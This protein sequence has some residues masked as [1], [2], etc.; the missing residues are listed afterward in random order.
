MI[1]ITE[2]DVK[3]KASRADKPGGQNVNHRSTKIE[4]W[5]NIDDLPLNNIEKKLIKGKLK[6]HINKKNEIWIEEQE[7]RTQEANKQI[8]LQRL[9]N[10]INDALQTNPPRIPT[11]PSYFTKIKRLQLKQ[12]NKINYSN[13]KSL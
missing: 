10:L 3:I 11:E 6:N 12:K 7:Q 2:K 4:L 13:N 9:N 8:A 5:I 1:T